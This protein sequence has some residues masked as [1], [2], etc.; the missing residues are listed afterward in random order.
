MEIGYMLSCEEHPPLDLVRHARYAEEAGFSFAL[1]SDHFHP[2]ID[3]QGESPFVWSVVGAIGVSTETI[4]LGT[5]VTCPLVRIHPAIVAQAA[6]T[7]AASMPG[8]FFLGVGTGE[9]LNEHV[10]GDRWPS[11]SERRQML[12]EAVALMRRLW[13]GE[14]TSW[15]GRHYRVVDARLYTLP[16][17]TIEVVMAAGGPA[18]AELAGRIGDGLVST[19]PEAD[20]VDAFSKAGGHGPRFGQLTVCYAETESDARR[21]ALEWWPNAGLRGPLGQ[22]LPLPSDF[23]QAATMVDEETI[24]QSVVCGPDPDAHLEGIRKFADAGFD[25]VYVHQVGPDQDAFFDF[26]ATEV[27]AQAEGIR[28]RGAVAR[29]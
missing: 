6:A 1:I 25:H 28:T 19:A 13:E 2:W 23:E 7:A 29:A 16:D 18:A 24:A 9:H 26:Y 12:E 17:E 27:L 11:T 20:L 10:F 15:D 4:R 21:T 22:E 5:G 8:R 14:L 3:R